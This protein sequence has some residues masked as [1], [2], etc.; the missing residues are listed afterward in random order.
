MTRNG[1]TNEPK[2]L[3]NVPAK[4]NH[5]GRGSDLRL[6]MRLGWIGFINKK[7]CSPFGE[8]GAQIC[9][10]D[11]FGPSC[12]PSAMTTRT[13]RRYIALPSF[14]FFG[15]VVIR[16]ACTLRVL[17]GGVKLGLPRLSLTLTHTWWP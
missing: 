7:P 2:R 3:M 15:A 9:C 1:M 12:P 13:C 4:R 6:W 8:Q 14:I 11:Q 17:R 16:S 10:F 5:A